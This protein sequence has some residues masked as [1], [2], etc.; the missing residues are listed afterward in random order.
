MYAFTEQ[1]I[2]L[3]F[4]T[5]FNSMITNTVMLVIMTVSIVGIPKMVCNRQK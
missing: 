2:G 3:A 4:L 5:G 1:A